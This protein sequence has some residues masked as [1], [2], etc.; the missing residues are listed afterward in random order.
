MK[1]K[2][3]DGPDGV[4]YNDETDEIFVIVKHH[5]LFIAGPNF[6]KIGGHYDLHFKG[7][8]PCH[9]EIALTG[10]N[11]SIIRLDDVPKG[12]RS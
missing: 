8:K 3:Y 1:S 4:F 11:E 9:R 2:Y 7:V 10:F 12:W 6:E 5:D